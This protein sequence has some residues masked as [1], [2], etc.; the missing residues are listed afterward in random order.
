MLKMSQTRDEFLLAYKPTETSIRYLQYRFN[1]ENTYNV[2]IGT[3]LF[4]FKKRTRLGIDMFQ[5]VETEEF[6]EGFQTSETGELKFPDA[7]TR[8]AFEASLRAKNIKAAAAI[9]SG[10]KEGKN[11][12]AFT[13]LEHCSTLKDE[14]ILEMAIGPER[15]I[16]NGLTGLLHASDISP[17]Q[18]LNISVSFK[19]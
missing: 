4:S 9:L 8:Q 1:A 12:H 2:L 15:N 13:V 3:H 16:A 7:E 11:S 6:K 18:P 10:F 14:S 5:A 17:E 19:Q